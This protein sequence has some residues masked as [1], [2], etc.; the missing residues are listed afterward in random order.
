MTHATKI[1][2]LCTKPL[3][4]FIPG[5]SP[6]LTYPHWLEPVVEALAQVELALRGERAPVGIILS[7]PPQ[8]GK[9]SLVLH[10]LTR[11]VGRYPHLNHGY[12]T[13]G[14]RLSN[15]QSRIARSIAHGAGLDLPTS[16]LEEWVTP[17]GGGVIWTSIGGMITGSPISGCAII[18]DPFRGRAD[19]ESQVVRERADDFYESDW[20]TRIHPQASEFIINTRW[21][22]DD[23]AGRRIKKDG[24]ASEGGKWIVINIPAISVDENGMEHSAWEEGRPLSWLISEK[25]DRLTSYAWESMYM[26]N[27]RPKGGALFDLATTCKLSDV[28]TTGRVSIGIDLAYTAKTHADYT[29]AVTL[30]ESGGKTYVQNVLRFQK[31]IED[32]TTTLATLQRQHPSATMTWHASGMES[33]TVESRLRAAGVRVKCKAATNDKFVRSQDVAGAWKAGE[34]IVPFD[35][36]WSHDFID[37]VQ[38]FTGIGDKHDD[39]VDALASAFSALQ[40]GPAEIATSPATRRTFQHTSVGSLRN[41]Y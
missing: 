12:C 21:H 3:G 17:Q 30:I 6:R 2:S 24:L 7:V 39:Q 41:S 33:A 13:Y 15:K 27:P 11:L 38:S 28:P 16:T 14:Q 40:S 32:S 26:G 5:A 25:R 10:W 1:P 22:V 31:A 4:E 35:A 34:V 19:A 37:E 36:S 8:F 29:A 23:L 20:M 18:D 9:S